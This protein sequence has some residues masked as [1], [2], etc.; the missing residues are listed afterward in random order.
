MKILIIAD[1]NSPLNTMYKLMQLMKADV[2]II[3]P[4]SPDIQKYID[5]QN[6]TSVLIDPFCFTDGLLEYLTKLKFCFADLKVFLCSPKCSH[7][8]MSQLAEYGVL[9]YIRL[10]ITAKTLIE[11]LKRYTCKKSENNNIFSSAY[12][13][14]IYKILSSLGFNMSHAGSVFLM[15]MIMFVIKNNLYCNLNEV[16]KL[17][18]FSLCVSCK[19]IE[20]NVNFAIK[21]AWESSDKQHNPYFSDNKTPSNKEFIYTIANYIFYNQT[22]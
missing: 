9:E 19:K 6:T 8:N 3:P 15:F 11:K 4:H 5:P 7:W 14:Q 1:K 17:L 2:R 10:P 16:Y 13:P 21:K 18:A 12:K 20:C 22:D